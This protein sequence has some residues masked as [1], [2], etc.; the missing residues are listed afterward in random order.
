MKKK[1]TL[2]TWT[3]DTKT[4][5]VYAKVMTHNKKAAIDRISL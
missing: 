2:K 5:V 1:K 4:G 3:L